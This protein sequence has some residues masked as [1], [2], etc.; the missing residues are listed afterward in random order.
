MHR[1]CGWKVQQ[2]IRRRARRLWRSEQSEQIRP[3]VSKPFCGFLCDEA[4]RGASRVL[5]ILCPARRASRSPSWGGGQ[6]IHAGWLLELVV[7]QSFVYLSRCSNLMRETEGCMGLV[8]RSSKARGSLTGGVVDFPPP[9]HQTS[10]SSLWRR[11]FAKCALDLPRASRAI[12]AIQLVDCHSLRI[13]AG[14][15]V[16]LR[17][18]FVEVKDDHVVSRMLPTG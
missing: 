14:V 3:R 8:L 9:R 13:A 15:M 7:H 2:Q 1:G 17:N 12:L 11:S 4:A 10:R 18:V 6:I 5:R 16:A